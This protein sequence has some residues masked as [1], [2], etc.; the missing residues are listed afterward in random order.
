MRRRGYRTACIGKWALGRDRKGTPLNHGFH[1]FFGFIDQ[2]RAHRYYPE[3]LWRNK[4]KETY[5]GNPQKRTHYAHDLFTD[6]ALAFIDR[7][8][9]R[10]RENPFFLYLSYTVPHPDL[11]VPEVPEFLQMLHDMGARLWACKMSVDM[12]GLT[13]EDMFEG[14][15]DIINVNEFIELSDGSQVIFV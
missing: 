11:D 10:N 2:I 8:T 3:W 12:M 5:P 13:K 14:V 4:K 1:E 9:D 7:N 6:E 15:E